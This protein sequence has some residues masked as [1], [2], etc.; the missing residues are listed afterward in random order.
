[1]QSHAPYRCMAFLSKNGRIFGNFD[2]IPPPT[3]ALL[4]EKIMFCA[5]V[6][7]SRLSS[8]EAASGLN[9]MAVKMSLSCTE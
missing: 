7:F 4:R 6:N 5:G 9:P 3:G 2:T 1:M 8:T